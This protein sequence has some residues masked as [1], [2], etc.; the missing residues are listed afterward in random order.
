MSPACA[1]ADLNIFENRAKLLRCKGL[2]DTHCGP[3]RI[4]NELALTT[5]SGH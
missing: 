2:K 3:S 1:K 4:P 5:R